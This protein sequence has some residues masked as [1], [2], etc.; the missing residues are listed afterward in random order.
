[1][2]QHH[3]MRNRAVRCQTACLESEDGLDTA[4]LS[5]FMRYEN[6]QERAFHKCLADLLKLRAEKQKQENGFASQ[7]HQQQMRRM[8]LLC[9]EQDVSY[10]RSRAVYADF[11]LE[12]KQLHE[13]DLLARKTQE[14]Q[15]QK[16]A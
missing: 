7:T 4:R 11:N 15:E 2:A 16:A 6:M 5:L 1:M 10:H 13:D 3:W 8:D 12:C 14:T 9:R